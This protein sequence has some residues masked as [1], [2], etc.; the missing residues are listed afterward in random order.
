MA[1]RGLTRMGCEGT[2]WSNGNV[3]YRDCSGS[4]MT[5]HICQNSANG[6]VPVVARQL[7][8]LTSI[9]EDVSLIPGLAQRVKDP[10]MP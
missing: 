3:L 7:T 6:G 9:Q 1:G 8:N 4:Y 2:F 5:A 10:A